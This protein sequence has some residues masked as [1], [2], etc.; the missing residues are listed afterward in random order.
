MRSRYTRFD[1]CLHSKRGNHISSGLCH[2]VG[3]VDRSH[4]PVETGVTAPQKKLRYASLRD[5]TEARW[6]EDDH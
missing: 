1:P 4:I 2:M 3:E 5:R 6:F